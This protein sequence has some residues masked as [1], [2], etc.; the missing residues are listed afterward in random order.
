MAGSGTATFGPNAANVCAPPS[1]T[2]VL[3]TVNRVA[4]VLMTSTFDVSP[5]IILAVFGG[6]KLNPTVDPDTSSS[7]VTGATVPGTKTPEPSTRKP[8]HVVTP[9]K[10][11]LVSR[12]IA[13]AE[14]ALF[15]T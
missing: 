9:A 10:L 8:V 11:V 15:A 12:P 1:M 14:L 7:A 5:G 6:M 2:A 4:L 3:P 13:V